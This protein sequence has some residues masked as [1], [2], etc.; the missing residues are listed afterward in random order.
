MTKQ[1]GYWYCR[2]CE[3]GESV[4]RI[5][6]S[7]N[8]RVPD[9]LLERLGTYFTYFDIQQRYGITFERFVHLN[10]IGAWEHY[11]KTA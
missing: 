8:H 3:Q 4:E 5:E 2:E 9:D 7:A 10:M 11:A 6:S 1:T